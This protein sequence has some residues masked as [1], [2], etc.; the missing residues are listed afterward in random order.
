MLLMVFI[1]GVQIGESRIQREWNAEKLRAA[2]VMAKQEQ[3]A[4]D[5]Q[6]SQSQI[7]REISNE[8]AKKSKA[9]GIRLPSIRPD[10]V[11][12]S[13][14]ISAGSVPT[15]SEAPAGAASLPADALSLTA[16][17]AGAVSCAQLS[18]G[19]AQTTLMLL[20]VQRWYQKQSAIEP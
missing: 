11:C 14:P 10:G 9:L 7:N 1:C 13:T 5:V 12:S 8:Y 20:E 17:D 2:L 18:K 6:Q 19:A 15:V 3:R 16:G 4:A